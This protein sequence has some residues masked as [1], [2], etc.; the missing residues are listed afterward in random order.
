MEKLLKELVEAHGVSG[1]E[2]EIRELIKQKVEKHADSLETDKMGNLIARKGSG[3]KKLMIATH[4]DQIGL[5]VRR[6]TEEG[7]IKI[8][9]VGGM[10]E[11]GIINQ[12]FT[13]HSSYGDQV[14]GVVAA[15]PPHLMKKEEIREVPEMKDL[16]I[17]IG[18]ED[19]EDVKDAGIR[20]GDYVS[21]ERGFEKLLNDYVTA[22]AFDN[23]VGC[24]TLIKLLKRFDED[25]EL[26]AV[27]STQEEVG[28]KG[29]RT[30]TFDIDPDVALAIDTGMAGDV[31]GISPDESDDATGD[32]AGIDMVQASGRGLISPESIREWLIETAE[33]KDHNY[34]RSLYEGGATDAASIQIQRDGYP[35]GSISIP[36]RHIHSPTEVV[37]LSDIEETVEFLEDAFSTMEEYF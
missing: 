2:S 19:E 8:S 18:A 27:F 9:K 20:V 34:F 16:F 29:V 22:P 6:I 14:T 28:T 31:P 30:S 24:A 15:K 1:N 35:T 4:M 26:V 37:K 11:T 13:V 12:R 23:R 33:E 25:Y 36:T 21:Y 32:G 10:F 17:D 5:S 3:G 7:F